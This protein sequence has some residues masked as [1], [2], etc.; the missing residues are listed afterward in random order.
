MEARVGIERMSHIENRELIDFAMDAKDQ[1]DILDRGLAQIC[2]KK[3]ELQDGQVVR[4][5]LAN[6]S[7][8]HFSLTLTSF[9]LRQ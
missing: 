6:Q 3:Q 1:K 8:P 7:L 5:S 9:P 4:R 2:T